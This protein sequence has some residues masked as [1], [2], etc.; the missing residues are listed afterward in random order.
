[1]AN[2]KEI[3]G[4]I[5]SI[6]STQQI[7]KAMKMVAASKLNKVQHKVLQIKPYTQNLNSIVSNITASGVTNFAEQYL[8]Q[9]IVKNI[10][11]IVM[12][13]DKGLCGSFNANI[14]KY[15]MGEV[16]R[17]Q[18]LY[19]EAE[20]HILPIGE[21]VFSAFS[22]KDFKIKKEFVDAIANLSFEKAQSV[23]NFSK[24]AFLDGEYDRIILVYSNFKSVAVQKP[25]TLDYLPLIFSDKSGEDD[26]NIYP[27]DYIYEPSQVEIMQ[28]LI[29][30][31]LETQLY[32]AMLE[33]SASEHSARMMT[34]NKATDNAGEILRSLKIS[35]NR[36][37]QAAIT[38]EISE[39]V[40]GTEALSK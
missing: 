38:Q 26:R 20:I 14:I 16:N 27:K 29:P 35:Y 32:N 7:T 33:S 37:R 13:S 11:F 9:R 40:S 5:A 19:Q 8:T 6:T 24:K 1:M 17:V 28:V 12:A 21:K 4:K 39:I 3:V 30:K 18:S 15:A 36:T 23:A 10:L 31:L 2:I 22:K 34:M 25:V